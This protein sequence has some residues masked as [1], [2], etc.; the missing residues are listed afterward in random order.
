[1]PKSETLPLEIDFEPVGRR[2]ELSPRGTLLEAARGGGIGLVSLCGGE[3]WCSSCRIRIMKGQVNPPTESERRSIGTRDLDKGFRLACQVIPETS[4]VVDIPPESLSSPQRLQVEGQQAPVTLSPAVQAVD[5][6][7]DPPSLTDL[8]GDAER[9]LA[10]LEKALSR[11]IKASYPMLAELSGRIREQQWTLR[12]AVRKNEWIAVLPKGTGFYGLAVDIGTTKIALYLLDLE[13]GVVVAKKGAMNPQI[14]YGEDILSR[15]SYAGQHEDGRQTLQQLLTDTFNATV[16]ELCQ[17]VEISPE[18]IL[19]AVVVGNTAMH[20]FFLG[21][22]VQQL[23]YTPY[24]PAVT[25]AVDVPAGNLDLQIAPGG[26]VHFLPNIAGYVGADHTA[27]ILSTDLHS[28]SDITMVIDIGTNTEISLAAGGE[29]WSC[30]CA[31]GP[32]FEG[33]HINT[34][35]RAAP[36]AI[37]RVKIDDQIHLFTIDALPP[38]GICGSGILDIVAELKS[39]GII[40][41]KGA[42]QEGKPWIRKNS[43]GHLEFLLA[44]ADQTGHA[45][46]IA[47]SRRDINEIQL[48]KA[49]IRSG[50]DLLLQEAGLAAED[51]DRVLIA[52]AFGSYISIPNAI[53]IGML[54]DLPLERFTQ[55]GNAAG[56]GAI[57]ALLSRE[58]RAQISGEILKVHYL[59]LTNSDSFQKVFLEA[60]YL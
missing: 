51:L 40:D 33:A 35:M 44:P 56:M 46:D 14:A 30:S 36:G 48:A 20:H 19:E 15:I 24:I 12:A 23:A 5:L 52:G 32:A 49:A 59:E 42:L 41:T 45:Q 1:M 13:T 10:A 3:G 53:L 18:Q 57:Q 38:V 4:L 43:A 6:T 47:I 58:K 21:L 7:L 37:E 25:A 50:I 54:P 28:A 31:S 60:M 11:K 17:Q 8:R 55:V 26:W 29:L 9:V 27:V 16:A 34:G 22:P 2:V 39:T